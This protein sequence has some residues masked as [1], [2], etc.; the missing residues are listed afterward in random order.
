MVG[1]FSKWPISSMLEQSNFGFLIWVIASAST[2]NGATH[3]NWSWASGLF[4][5]NFFVFSRRNSAILFKTKESRRAKKTTFF[6]AS[7]MKMIT[8]YYIWKIIIFFFG[9]PFT[10]LAKCSNINLLIKFLF[11][12]LYSELCRREKRWATCWLN[13]ASEII[14]FF[15]E[16]KTFGNAHLPIWR[17]KKQKK[18]FEYIMYGMVCVCVTENNERD[19]KLNFMHSGY[20]FQWLNS[21]KCKLRLQTIIK[22]KI[23]SIFRS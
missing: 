21:L 9:V 17:Q 1:S 13:D 18:W 3:S 12:F 16:V 22:T 15:W 14:Y 20:G 4:L 2:K 11:F 7:K 23:L 5:H 19:G 6:P 10:L 8:C